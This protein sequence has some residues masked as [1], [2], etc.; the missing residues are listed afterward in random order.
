M[1]RVIALLLLFCCSLPLRAETSLLI[2]AKS[3]CTRADLQAAVDRYVDALKSGAP[4]SMPLA[5]GAKYIENRKEIPL[6]RGIWQ[7]PLPI[8]LH[9]SLLDVEACETFTE[10]ISAKSRHQY[11]LGTRLKVIDKK[12]SEIEALVTDKDDWLFNADNYLKY[13]SQEKWDIL[14]AAQRTDRQTLIIAANAYFDVFSDRSAAER[15]PWNIPCARLEGGAYTNPDNDPKATCTG[16]PPLEG[17][18]KITNR[19]FIVDLDMGT[20]VG[21]VDFGEKDGWPDSHMFRLENGK[22]RYVHTLTVCPNG[23]ELPKPK[24]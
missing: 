4:S 8:D 7:N 11:V 10:I 18:L 24:Q 22:V 2:S 9:R 23:C 14:P 21:L 6:G 19:R 15:V 3:G 16:G 17:T 5:S 13:A 12:I 20:V 1:V